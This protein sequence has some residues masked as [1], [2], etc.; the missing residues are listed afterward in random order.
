MESLVTGKVVFD[1]GSRPFSDA[2][3]YVR[4]VDVSRVDAAS[5]IV[6]ETILRAVSLDMR[7]ETSFAFSIP[8]ELPERNAH[9]NISVHIDVD[10]DGKLSKGDYFTTQSF[11][12]LTHG[13]SNHVIVRVTPI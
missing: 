3:V 12:V 6:A 9:Y 7:K 1:E 11:P 5:D 4:L 8:G 2:T 10:N 13:Y